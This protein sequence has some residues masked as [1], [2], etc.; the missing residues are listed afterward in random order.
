MIAPTR[1]KH[2][3]AFHT[4]GTARKSNQDNQNLLETF[5]PAGKWEL[6]QKKM[7]WLV[8]MGKNQKASLP[9]S[10]PTMPSTGVKPT[11]KYSSPRTD[12]KD[13]HQTPNHR[14]RV[15]KLSPLNYNYNIEMLVCQLELSDGIGSLRGSR[16]NIWM[17]QRHIRESLWISDMLHLTAE[18][19]HE[20]IWKWNVEGGDKTKKTTKCK[21]ILEPSK[22]G[23]SWMWT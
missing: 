2:P 16:Q 9:G 21:M 14:T 7:T 5:L 17:K 18:T 19:T 20:S 1:S 12:Y 15:T 6:V 3:S 8:W 23:I 11:C 22:T 10:K 4:L 13:P